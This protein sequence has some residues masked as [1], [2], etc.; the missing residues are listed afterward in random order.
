MSK[1]ALLI[2]LLLCASAR[3]ESSESRPSLLVLDLE[4]KGATAL[5]AEAATLGVVRGLRALDV[6]Q[7]LSADDARRLLALERTKQLMGADSDTSSVSRALGTR[8]SVIGSVVQLIPS[9]QLQVELRLLDSSAGKVVSQK[10]FGPVDSMEAIAAAM[11]GLAQELVAPLLQAEQGTLVVRTREEAAEV[12]VDDQLM[13]STPM[14]KPLALSRGSHRVMVRKDGFIAQAFSV[15]IE[16]ERT[17]EQDVT[18][19]P[20]PDYAEAYSQRHGRLRTGAWIASGVALGLLAGAVVMDRRVVEPS[21]QN[22]FLP[23]QLALSQASASQLSKAGL[24][25]GQDATRRACGADPA[26]CREELDALAG[27]LRVQQ[28]VTLGAAGLGLAA[29]GVASYLWLT[30]EDPNRYAGLV[31]GLSWSD[32]P[33]ISAALGF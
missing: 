10:A 9:T 33:G 8:H 14:Q 25:Q 7:V 3:G 16:P 26:A 29:V 21:Y 13:G 6:F 19:L 15:R 18:L 28:A 2:P 17:T 27:P 31:A 5:Q 11:P 12:L 32:G 30:G 4:P 24:N 1:L 20:S 22:E 23:R